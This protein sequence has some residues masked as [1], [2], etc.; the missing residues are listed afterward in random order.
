MRSWRLGERKR[1]N[2]KSAFVEVP[3]GERLRD[4]IASVSLEVGERKRDHFNSAFVEVWGAE[5]RQF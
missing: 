3:F 1:D 5:K 2:Y 4:I